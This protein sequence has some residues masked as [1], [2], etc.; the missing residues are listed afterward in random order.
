MT[1]LT[2]LAQR[3][4]AG[5]LAQSFCHACSLLGL[6]L[7]LSSPASALGPDAYSSVSAGTAHTCAILAN[8]GAIDCWGLNSSGQLGNG[9]NT[10]SSLP[11]RVSGISGATAIATGSTHS[12]AVVAGIV[13]CW[14]FNGSGQLGNNTQ[15]SSLT[16]VNA[17][18]ISSA[19]SV[20]VGQAHT[21]AALA[22]GAVMCWG[23]D[24]EG[25]LGTGVL[26]PSGFLKIPTAIQAGSVT[27]AT[28]MVAG[29]VST[30]A[31]TSAGAVF[32][33][34]NGSIG[35]LG[36]GGTNSRTPVAVSV[37][38]GYNNTS[39][40]AL[41]MGQ[42]HACVIV[43][44]GS[45]TLYCWGDNSTGQQGDGTLSANLV[46]YPIVTGANAVAAGQNH[47]C[48]TTPSGVMACTGFNQFG[49]LGDGT[50]LY[51][52][53]YVG[54]VGITAALPAPA[55]G[56]VHSCV[57]IAGGALRCWGSN[58]FGQLGDG[59][60]AFSATAV[61]VFG[62]SS[63]SGIAAGNLNACA[64]IQDGTVRCWGVGGDLLGSNGVSPQSNIPVVIAGLAGATQ[65]KVG[66]RHACALVGASVWC[67]GSND[68]GQLGRGS[69]SSGSAVPAAVTGI[70]NAVHISAGN[71]HTCAA[72]SDGSVKCWGDNQYLKLGVTGIGFSATP[73]TAVSA[74]SGAT[75][76]SA[77]AFHSCAIVTGGG[78]RCWG[79][80]GSGQS[81]GVAGSPSLFYA[82]PTT[83]T[84]I[85]GATSIATSDNNTCAVTPT[86]ASGPVKCWGTNADGQLG[87]A[88]PASGPST[89]N[90]VDNLPD[91]TAVT[92]AS[93]HACARRLSG[94]VQCWGKA[95][96]GEGNGAAL[97]TVAQVS[98]GQ[99]FTCAVAGSSVR[100]IGANGYG[101]LGDGT[102]PV[103]TPLAKAVLPGTC[104]LDIDG[105][106]TIG[107]ATDGVML[108]RAAFGVTGSAV[109]SGA[110]GA[111]AV[112]RVWD[113][114]G[115]YLTVSCKIGSS[116]PPGA[117]SLDLDG[118][119][120]V[121]GTT[122]G[123]MLIRI[124][125]GLPGNVI[126]AG[127]VATGATR[128]NWAAIRSYLSTSCGLTGLP[129]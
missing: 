91:A 9:T 71:S 115:G 108:V 13:K 48:V 35:Q 82:T 88:T 120:Q 6:S 98:T 86:G 74:G 97:A 84:G 57:I 26:S 117:C 28:K 32:C 45:A 33:W 16:P 56:G 77:S 70:A 25:Q 121:R 20:G 123:L 81:S 42:R 110:I 109:T 17:S 15:T 40:V 129:P 47:T 29:E 67:W 55:A 2:Q 113:D 75:Q 4:L 96:L 49:A 128:P 118:D 61:S 73:V 83:I 116:V 72:L 41:S 93:F 10:S 59:T 100:C 90:T 36:N 21:C 5:R 65:V 111:N 31:L 19:V 119:G 62:I 60:V 58:A 94:V 34:G 107:A 102:G 43:N 127:A 18:G 23:N 8:G 114:V 46:P 54:V 7:I 101:Q 104:S 89:I 22:S 63:A 78:V 37:A 87:V 66:G 68:S 126:T 92:A 125:L 39:V 80:N 12:C 95:T 103:P 105:D 1:L 14:G 44:D 53:S 38:N 30:C 79:Y 124:A 99:D 85:S 64:L 122:D 24:L 50:L 106:G 112:R 27:G 51:S 52:T 3:A 76:V 11:A 69:T